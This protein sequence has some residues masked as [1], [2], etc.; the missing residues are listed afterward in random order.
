M[1]ALRYPNRLPVKLLGN[2]A[3]VHHVLAIHL[4]VVFQ[5]FHRVGIWLQEIKPPLLCTHLGF[6]ESNWSRAAQMHPFF[7]PGSVVVPNAN[8]DGLPLQPGERHDDGQH[9]PTNGDPGVEPL[10]CERKMHSR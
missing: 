5:S 7:A 2:S 9:G 8:L 10:L 4:E 1:V 6:A 3:K